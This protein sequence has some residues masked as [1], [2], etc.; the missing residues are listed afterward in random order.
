MGIEK[1]RSDHPASSIAQTSGTTDRVTIHC[2]GC[3]HGLRV[4]KN[5]LGR[6]LACRALRSLLPGSADKAFQGHGFAASWD[7]KIILP[8]P[9]WGQAARVEAASPRSLG[10][11]PRLRAAVFAPAL[12][13]RS[14]D[15]R[16]RTWQRQEW[17]DR[18]WHSA[19]SLHRTRSEDSTPISGRPSRPDHH[20]PRY[21]ASR[22]RRAEL[23]PPRCPTATSH[24]SLSPAVCGRCWML[25]RAQIRDLDAE[26]AAARKWAGAL[27]AELDRSAARCRALEESHE[28]L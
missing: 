25:S 12:R 20:T 15:S 11:L 26:R 1:P 9:A 7:D 13:T 27:E 19:R 18:L 21:S 5:W 23:R 8:C 10:P 22:S 16:Q 3:G 2:P 14:R 28:A 6:K 17:P 4:C 24:P